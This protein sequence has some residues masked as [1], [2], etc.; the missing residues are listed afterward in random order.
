MAILNP[1][2]ETPGEHPGQA[3]R[4]TLRTHVSSA[5]FAAF[6]PEPLSAWETFGRW[7]DF[8]FSFEQGDLGLAFFDPKKEGYEDFEEGWGNDYYLTEIP[9]GHVVAHLFDGEDIETMNGG[10][11]VEPYS[12]FLDDITTITAL[13]DGDQHEVFD[14]EP[15]ASTWDDI[16][17]ETVMFTEGMDSFES[18]DESDWPEPEEEEP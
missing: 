15:Y 9:T 5:E 12:W 16:T 3:E 1:R 4:W 7:Y 13:F 14:F 18:F 8:K 6:T 11:D 17:S 2:F 10:W